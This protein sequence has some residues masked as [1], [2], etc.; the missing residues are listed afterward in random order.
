M[1]YYPVLLEL[2][3]KNVLIVG[4]GKVAQRKVETLLECGALLSIVSKGLTANLK[5]LIETRR[6]HF[7]SD[8]FND[9]HLDNIFLV[10]AATNDKQLNH[11]VSESAK[12]RGLLINAVDQPPDCNFIVPSI[13][14]K[15]DL[16]I[17][18]STSGK[19][20]ALAKR[21]REE[22][23]TQFGNEYKTFLVM[24]GHL[25]KIILS[26]KFSQEENNRIFFEIVNSDIL[27][28]LKKGDW[29]VVKM[30]LRRILPSDLIRNNFFDDIKPS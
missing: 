14:K 30:S 18:I 27:K 10:V 28:A 11:R 20:P 9:K 6:V 15:G 23:E 29:E 16:L 19:S 26:K 8:E 12:K 17:A 13:I 1:S 24:M 22:I 21:L 7:L 4:G 3:N 5:A 25:R 2:E